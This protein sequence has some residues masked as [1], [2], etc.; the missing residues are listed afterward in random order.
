MSCRNAERR[1]P[2]TR[3]I[4]NVFADLGF[5]HPGERRS[6]VRLAYALNQVL[7]QRK[8]SQVMRPADRVHDRKD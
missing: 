6:K 3:S 5:P 7:K 4:A 1:E 8:L 2:V